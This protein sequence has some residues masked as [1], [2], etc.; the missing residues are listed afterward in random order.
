MRNTV[1]AA[2]LALAAC[3]GEPDQPAEEAAALAP[4]AT[5]APEPAA[6]LEEL[7]EADL[8][9]V[10]LAGELGC[11]FRREDAKAPIWLGRGDVA[12]DAGAEAVVK[13]DGA[14]HE[15]AMAGEGGYSAMADGARFKG[16]NIALAIAKTGDEPIEEE[17]Q[18]AMES[19]IYPATLTFTTTSEAEQVVRGLLE[20]GP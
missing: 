16:G 12:D 14:V 2:A 15:L 17:P 13:L 1:L 11:S 7:G 4:A 3:G 18:I 20:C 10:D 19:P 9:T 5:P 6:M 8:A